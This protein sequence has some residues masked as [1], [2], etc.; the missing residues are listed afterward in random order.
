MRVGFIGLGTMGGPMALNASA[1]GFSLAVH[2]VRKEAALPHLKSGATWADTAE[3]LA[4]D[5]DVI[6]TSLPGPPEVEAVAD[7][8]IKTMRPGT[9][10][11]DL[12]TNSPTVVRN[13]HERF[14][15]KAIAVL[16]APVSGGTQRGEIAEAGFMGGW[17]T[18]GIRSIPPG[19]R[20]YRRSGSVYRSHWRRLRGKA[21]A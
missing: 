19:S 5:A 13:L 11:F 17:G 20:R 10:W 21:R 8:L 18:G 6:L 15:K 2:D 3:D 9:A 16:D 7:G 1:G 14:A 4:S 12:S